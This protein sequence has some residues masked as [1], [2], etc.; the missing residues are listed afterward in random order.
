[1]GTQKTQIACFGFWLGEGKTGEL[2][3]VA[4][5]VR[6]RYRILS[7]KHKKIGFAD[8]TLHDSFLPIP[9]SEF[10]SI[11]EWFAQGVDGATVTKDPIFGNILVHPCD[12]ADEHFGSESMS[13]VR[14]R[15]RRRVPHYR[16]KKEAPAIG[17][18]A[19]T[20]PLNEA[21]SRGSHRLPLLLQEAQDISRARK[22]IEELE[23]ISTSLLFENMLSF[24]EERHGNVLPEIEEKVRRF[25][26][27][28]ALRK[29]QMFLAQ[30]IL[31]ILE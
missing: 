5:K 10:Y 16:E 27:L 18:A 30:K 29:E 14:K 23:D 31:S 7:I 3:S 19:R 28:V 1:M 8:D 6:D 20:L 24:L 25:K 12:Y 4:C 9:F 17:G 26:E 22:I 15:K 11:L 13:G 21:G 2:I